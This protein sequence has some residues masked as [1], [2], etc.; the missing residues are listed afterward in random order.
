MPLLDELI[1]A[2][3]QNNNKI[4]QILLKKSKSVLNKC[5][6]SG[7]TLL[8]LAIDKGN[9][10]IIQELLDFKADINI[11]N[12]KKKSPLDIAVN[13]NN[14]ELIEILLK[15]GADPN[16]PT[17]NWAVLPK[18][19]SF[20]LVT[21]VKCNRIE[22]VKKLLYYQ[23][24]PH[25][26]LRNRNFDRVTPLMIAIAQGNSAML[27]EFLKHPIGKD[28]I[29]FYRNFLISMVEDKKYD[30]KVLNYFLEYDKNAPSD[31]IIND[32][33]LAEIFYHAA[34]T[35]NLEIIEM[36]IERYPH[37]IN[38]PPT[39]ESYTYKTT[40][41]EIALKNKNYEVAILLY[42]QESVQKDFNM[43]KKGL[44]FFGA[45]GQVNIVRE[46]L[47]YVPEEMKN[48]NLLKPLFRSILISG[49]TEDAE[50]AEMI[51]MLL[52]DYKAV[53]AQ[54]NTI[55]DEGTPID[56]DTP[57][58]FAIRHQDPKIVEVLLEDYSLAK[59][60]IDFIVNRGREAKLFP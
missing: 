19:T 57:L 10:E 53:R 32:S 16:V 60:Q 30:S 17:S 14:I 2:I 35:N 47:E 59:E 21:A 58:E 1:Q 18:S 7:E 22:I 40:P 8:T 28:E 29:R 50:K 23:A 45:A 56:E 42:K 39:Q 37:V 52:K 24:N 51:K 31:Q 12:S 46:L 4:F 43:V 36:F 54:I 6:S 15:N 48:I 33:V 13:N 5:H 49:N 25:Q 55:I 20:P 11:P 9:N 3:K 27:K 26:I 41:F 34:A 44:L 38:I